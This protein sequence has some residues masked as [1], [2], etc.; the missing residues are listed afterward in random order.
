MKCPPLAVVSILV[1]ALLPACGAEERPRPEV[2]APKS[3][4]PGKAKP[5]PGDEHGDH[6]ERRE[7]GNADVGGHRLT[8]ASFGDVKAG[9]EA[10]FDV[11]VADGAGVVV[12]AWVGVESGRGSLKGK[13][14]GEDGVFHGHV[15]VPDPL[16]SGSALWFEL[17]SADGKKSS[18]SFPIP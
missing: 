4:D 10:V 9:G 6:G 12:R 3:P 7:L 8:V 17:E 5:V 16:P 13:L 15:E 18:T 14:D 11:E 1:S 2:D